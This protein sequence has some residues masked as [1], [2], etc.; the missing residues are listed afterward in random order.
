M[1]KT[2]LYVKHRVSI[3]KTPQR[4]VCMLNTESRSSRLLDLPSNRRDELF[5]EILTQE[6]T[7]TAKGAAITI[8]RFK[9]LTNQIVSTMG[10]AIRKWRFIA[11]DQLNRLPK[12]R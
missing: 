8:W 1:L 11:N 5:I 6:G 10:A 7:V 12:F 3:I 4:R 2:C 9:P